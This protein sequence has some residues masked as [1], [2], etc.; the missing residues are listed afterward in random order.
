[1]KNF[2]Y[3]YIALSA[4]VLAC[5]MTSC[6]GDIETAEEHLSISNIRF[7]DYELSKDSTT[8]SCTMTADV[9]YTGTSQ[10]SRHCVVED[11]DYVDKEFDVEGDIETD[12]VSHISV[13]LSGI[14][15]S[16]YSRESR[17]LYLYVG[18]A[19]CRFNM[20]N[21]TL[22]DV[23]QIEPYKIYM[24]KSA[25]YNWTV[26]DN[27]LRAGGFVNDARTYTT[28]LHFRTTSEDKDE[29]SFD[30]QILDYGTLLVTLDGEPIV[31][32][33]GGK[34]S[35]YQGYLDAKEHTLVLTFT[36]D[37]YH[38]YSDQY[39]YFTGLR[40]NDTEYNAQEFLTWD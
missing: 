9:I 26:F 16:K 38:L 36:Q 3:F 12:S 19:E 28:T 40:I 18:D 4:S 2:R 33:A 23:A 25:G 13:E 37:D 34:E 8:F 29:L 6:D 14:S 32:T 39:A 5:T 35:S 10:G 30:Y 11:E 21:P 24:E 20:L 22:K 1:M 17:R 15:L 31:K 7:S 27:V